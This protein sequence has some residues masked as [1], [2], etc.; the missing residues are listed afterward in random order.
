MKNKTLKRT[1]EL[2]KP[3]KKTIVIVSILSLFIAVIEIVRP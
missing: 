2:A 1:Y 3:H